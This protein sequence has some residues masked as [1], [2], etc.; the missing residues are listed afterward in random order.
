M[1]DIDRMLAELTQRAGEEIRTELLDA[2]RR[3]AAL[4]L[5]VVA[6]RL[7]LPAYVVA[8][9]A[10]VFDS[11]LNG[12]GADQDYRPGEAYGY[13]WEAFPGADTGPADPA[14]EAAADKFCEDLERIFAEVTAATAAKE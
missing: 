2:I 8:C 1:D 9:A 14:V 10:D 12:C 7:G 4:V 5:P 11:L 3:R 6:Q 13:T